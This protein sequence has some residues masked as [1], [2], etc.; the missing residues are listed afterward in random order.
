MSK[1][2]KKIEIGLFVEFL[3]H[4]YFGLARLRAVAFV[5]AKMQRIIGIKSFQRVSHLC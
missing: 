2:E 3:Y 4:N 5:W 1:K